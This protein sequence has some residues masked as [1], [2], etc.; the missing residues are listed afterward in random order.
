[1]I[2]VTIEITAYLFGWELKV[3]LPISLVDDCLSGVE[4]LPSKD[5]RWIMFFLSHA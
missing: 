2:S 4:E 5:D 3:N 1:M